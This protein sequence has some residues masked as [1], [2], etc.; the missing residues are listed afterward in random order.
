MSSSDICHTKYY[1]WKTKLNDSRSTFSNSHN[2][3]ATNISQIIGQNEHLT[4]KV[5]Q[6]SVVGADTP[7]ADV[8][9]LGLAPEDE[10]GVVTGELIVAVLGPALPVLVSLGRPAD[11]G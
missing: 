2:R 6:V 7:R 4:L 1:L 9:V 5:R 3:Q 11:P 10:D 8:G